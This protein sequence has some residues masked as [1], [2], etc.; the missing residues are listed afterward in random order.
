MTWPYPL[1]LVLYTCQ[2][3]LPKSIAENCQFNE[4]NMNPFRF[5]VFVRKGD[6]V[7][8]NTSVTKNY[9]PH[10]DDQKHILFDLY[11][12]TEQHPRY[13]EGA[14]VTKEGDFS[15]SLPENYSQ[16]SEMPRFDLS[17]F[18]G[19]SNIELRAVGKCGGIEGR[20]ARTMVLPVKYCS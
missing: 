4:I 12:S 6:R 2:K 11:S 7:E 8:V 18:F 3:T 13:T 1:I 19:R 14:S 16:L 9:V 15:I 20:K 5:D 10:R 17:M